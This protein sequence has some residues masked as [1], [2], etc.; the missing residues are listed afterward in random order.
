MSQLGGGGRWGETSGSPPRPGCDGLGSFNRSRRT[1]WERLSLWAK[2]D[3]R[4]ATRHRDG[5]R[6]G[7]PIHQSVL[8]PT[9]A[10]AAERWEAS[11]PRQAEHQPVPAS[12][13][14][15]TAATHSGGVAWS[16]QEA[17]T[18]A[19][20]SPPRRSGGT[21]SH[22]GRRKQFRWLPW[23]CLFVPAVE[24]TAQNPATEIR[25]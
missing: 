25:Q 16:P 4:G 6:F 20:P 10:S 13:G 7:D 1:S 5:M 11:V 23:S 18:A 14:L 15:G 3:R 21:L 9:R 24:A 8:V 19:P 22:G 2:E 12:A 17:G